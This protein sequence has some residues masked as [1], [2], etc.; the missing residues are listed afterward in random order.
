MS[1]SYDYYMSVT[2]FVPFRNK[3][4]FKRKEKLHEFIQHHKRKQNASE[5]QYKKEY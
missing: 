1:K 2:E 4:C 5:Y 3:I